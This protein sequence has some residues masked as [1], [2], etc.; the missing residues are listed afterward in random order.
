MLARPARSAPRPSALSSSATSGRSRRRYE[1]SLAATWGFAASAVAVLSLVVL[2]RE[3]GLHRWQAGAIGLFSAIAAIICGTWG[4][5]CS[6][7]FFHI[8]ITVATC[9]IGGLMVAGG[10]GPPTYTL[11]IL[12]VFTVCFAGLFFST[13]LLIAHLVLASAADIGALEWLGRS[14]S[15]SGQA[16]VTIA[17]LVSCAWVV[18]LLVTGMR[19]MAVRD[20]LTRLP[21]RNA[22]R[23]QTD[24]AFDHHPDGMIALVLLDLDRF[25]D[26]NDTLGHGAG[27]VALQEAARRLQE[28]VGPD[29]TVAR[30]GG[31]E[32]AVLLAD[33]ADADDAMA[34]AHA[35]AAALHTVPLTVDGIAV[36]L[37]C[38]VGVAVGPED[39]AAFES[40]LQHADVALYRAKADRGRVA[41]YDA[42]TDTNDAARL[43]LLADLRCALDDPDGWG[44]SVHYQPKTGIASQSVIGVE[45]LLRWE[46]PVR[47]TLPPDDFVPLAERTGLIGPLTDFVLDAGLALASTLR[48][49]GRS[50]SV[51]VNVPARV[52]CDH[53]FPAQV[54]ALAAQHGV[55]PSVLVVEITE[56]SLVDDP[57]Q[58]MLALSELA[59]LGVRASLDDFGTGYSSLA[60]LGR[61]ALDEIKI[62][63]Q[64]VVG[65]LTTSSDAAI[66]RATVDIGRTLGLE[67]VAEGVE[68]ADVYQLVSVLGCDVAQGF[69]LAH[70]M[71]SDVLIRWLDEADASGRRPP[72]QPEVRRPGRATVAALA[73]DS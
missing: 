19:R 59:A 22:L 50:L 43:S 41:R 61:L 10:G 28:A 58:A 36:Q 8:T 21:N 64:F 67:V 62:D 35:F 16:V 54:A 23:Y 73:A 55:S 31:D 53:G 66:V 27:D 65:A 47:G 38:S 46:H 2:D 9:M 72:T 68:D 39:G 49:A 45:A 34:R 11:S 4:R 69:Y 37:D 42:T 12:F 33:I 15:V 57:D 60:Y 18:R 6:N 32:F 29:G 3:P 17:A 14:S 71:A 40:L 25:K 48:S 5:R 51:A 26:I 44:L 30:L 70:P 20:Q 7:L 56:R 63:R 1:Q 52:L 13:R 24:A